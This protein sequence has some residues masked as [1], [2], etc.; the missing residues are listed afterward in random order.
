MEPIWYHICVPRQVA[1]ASELCRIL[2]QKAN[3]PNAKQKSSRQLLDGWEFTC[4]HL[5]QI[6]SQ[7][8]TEWGRSSDNVNSFQRSVPF[9]LMH[10]T[11][12]P[13][14][15]PLLIQPGFLR[16]IFPFSLELIR[17]VMGDP[18]P[19]PTPTH[20]WI[21]TGVWHDCWPN[22][23]IPPPTTKDKTM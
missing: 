15:Q 22:T 12:V 17:N 14:Q 7:G 5:F 18:A 20:L 10:Q 4:N 16:H 21:K 6:G 1:E 2:T 13:K 11:T 19:I 8:I 3:T 23:Q 9:G